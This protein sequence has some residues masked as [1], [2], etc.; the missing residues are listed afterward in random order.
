MTKKHPISF[1]LSLTGLLLLITG[2]CQTT[3]S[4]QDE[5]PR[6]HPGE[7][8]YPNLQRPVPNPIE[9]PFNY[10]YAIGQGTRSQDGSPGEAYWQ[11]ESR[12][13]LRAKLVPDENRVNGS[14]RIIYKNNS[15]FSLEQMVMELAQNLHLEGTIRKESA[16]VTGGMELL[17]V[18]VAGEELDP[19]DETNPNYQG[20]PGFLVD[21]TRLLLVLNQTVFPG[22][23]I[24]IEMEWTFIVPEQGAGGRMG[25]SRDNLFFISYWYPQMM[26]YDDVNGWFI[27]PFLGNA[28]FYHEF[29]DYELEVVAPDNWLIMGTGEFLNPEEVLADHVYQRYLQAG[30]SDEVITIVGESDLGAATRHNSDG[31]LTWKFSANKVRDVA[32]SAM[33]ES[34]WDGTRAPVGDRDG[35]G[36]PDY[37]RIHSFY[38]SDASHWPQQAEFSQHSISFL[39]EY[40]EYP[41]PWPHMTSI[42]GAGIIGGGMEYPMITL[43]G[44]YEHL[45]PEDLHEVTAHEFAHMWVPM[46]VN[47]NERRFT[48]FDEGFTSFNTHQTMA[49]RYPLTNLDLFQP[50]LRIAGTHL[51]GPIMRWSDYHYPG[52]AYGIASYPKPASILTALQGVIGEERFREAYLTFLKEWEYRHPYPWDFFR[53]VER[54]AGQD[55]E[56]FWRSWYYETWVLDQGIGEVEQTD[57][58]YRVEI[59]D[60]GE[61]PMPVHLLITLQDGTEIRREVPVDGWLRGQTRQEILLETDQPLSSIIIDPDLRYPD[62]NRSNNSWVPQDSP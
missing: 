36:I 15:P 59:I 10:Q 30:E 24:E 45:G 27:D 22:D 37:T 39:S 38:R 53:T 8:D 26:V 44:S 13:R 9:I 43:I 16:E 4:L 23:S 17:R 47:P 29:A 6:L 41:Y 62:I 48:W 40:L 28:E 46:I 61:I 25:R 51:E 50:Y 52:P 58:G 34:I 11:N 14:A 55:L 7:V 18:S 20:E 2:A 42:E 49:D 32:F 60:Y 57:A 12:Y 1:L 21:A 33:R 5:L 31:L 35:D 3:G 56:W 54:V 19:I